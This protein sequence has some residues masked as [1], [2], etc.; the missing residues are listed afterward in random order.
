MTVSVE[1]TQQGRAM[2]FLAAVVA[3]EATVEDGVEN[4]RRE[5]I[6]SLDGM[7]ALLRQ[8]ASR[9]QIERADALRLV[10]FAGMSREPSPEAVSRIVQR[11]P[12]V[13]F[14]L[15]GTLYDP[16]DITRFN[17]KE[18]HFVPS[19]DDQTLLVVDDRKAIATFWQNSYLESWAHNGSAGTEAGS[20]G[21]HGTGM[22]QRT[23]YPR[24]WYFEDIN[25]GGAELYLNINY[26][27]KDLTGVYM[28]PFTNWNDKMSS[29]WMLGS[30]ASVLCEDINWSGQ[31]WS[32]VPSP[33]G[34][35][36]KEMD[37]RPF[38]WNDRTSS[39]MTW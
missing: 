14:M 13:P 35:E 4:L 25:L 19:A 11:V 1:R 10:N 15:N 39:M 18:L 34:S 7:L 17:G 20:P 33:Y 27:Y 24:T 9:A 31:T 5:G 21:Q 38:G 30:H 28:W 29:Y 12:S 8:D 32:R 2:A 26:G 3:G 16:N 22:E 36:F 37:L 23:F 6:D